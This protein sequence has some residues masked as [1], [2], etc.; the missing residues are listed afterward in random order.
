MNGRGPAPSPQPAPL[1]QNFTCSPRPLY[2]HGVDQAQ[3]IEHQL[4]ARLLRFRSQSDAED[5]KQLASDLI[6]A[7]R[8][9]DARGVVVLAQDPDAPDP[10][11]MVLE[12]SAWYLD[13][14]LARA[15]EAFIGGVELA[16][17]A[18]EP[19]LWIGRCLL[20]RGDPLRAAH[21]LERCLALDPDA[22]EAKV[23]LHRALSRIDRIE[24][25]DRRRARSTALTLPPPSEEGPHVA[26]SP[27]L[28]I[29]ALAEQCGSEAPVDDGCARHTTAAADG[30]RA[31][32]E[33][34]AEAIPV[35]MPAQASAADRVS[36]GGE[37]EPPPSTFDRPDTST[38][39]ARSGV[40]S[41]AV[42][43]PS[44]E[45]GASSAGAIEAPE[46]ASSAGTLTA[47]VQVSV[48]STDDWVERV[49]A[50]QGEY[51]ESDHE[52]LASP[53][54]PDELQTSDAADDASR[55]AAADAVASEP[56]PASSESATEPVEVDASPQSSASASVPAGTLVELTTADTRPQTQ[57]GA[58]ESEPSRS[59]VPPV[60]TTPSR[61]AEALAAPS[62]AVTQAEPRETA[63]PTETAPTEP[64]APERAPDTTQAASQAAPPATDVDAARDHDEREIDLVSG[65]AEGL[66][67]GAFARAHRR[68]LSSA[69]PARVRGAF[70]ARTLPGVTLSGEEADWSV[71]VDLASLLGMTAPGSLAA[72]T[73]TSSSGAV[74]AVDQAGVAE[75][76]LAAGL[77]ATGAQGAAFDADRDETPLRL[78]LAPRVVESPAPRRTGGVGN[79][80]MTIATMAVCA[81]AG[82]FGVAEWGRPWARLAVER[83]GSA[84]SSARAWASA[85]VATQT[86]VD[87]E[88]EDAVAAVALAQK[89]VSEVATETPQATQGESVLQPA[90]EPR[91]SGADQRAATEA[92]DVKPEAD[93]PVQAVAAEDTA[94]AISDGLER[95]R[96]AF[97]RNDL[98]AARAA[99]RPL[100]GSL[101]RSIEGRMLHAQLLVRE[102]RAERALAVAKP[103]RDLDR[104]TPLQLAVIGD[105]LHAVGEV[106][107]AAGAYELALAQ[108]PNSLPA[109]VGR[110]EIHLRAERSDDAIALLERARAQADGAS[111][112]LRARLLTALG[113]AFMQRDREG[114]RELS[115]DAL[116]QALSLPNPPVEA[117][118]WLGESQA[119]R[120]TP[121]A[122]AAYTRYLELLPKGR[123]AARA[124]RALGPLLN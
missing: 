94:H 118:F 5:P 98:E 29:E 53:E 28:G 70:S 66:P 25:E 62:G 69:P 51:S 81:A 57:S 109:L 122:T 20:D 40:A 88:T 38:E 106:N 37:S 104:R 84:V 43:T 123:Y 90:A 116:R 74:A 119:A 91:P 45:A 34:P 8:Y 24:E 18:A 14:D 42:L 75:D 111:A 95:V 49:S 32:M 50:P 1:A 102:G 59:E 89:A 55:A 110:A 79:V 85:A 78:S 15:L 87:A 58:S 6:R 12:G 121:E 16:P 117:H 68:P 13:G 61:V 113:H 10:G 26:T 120:R 86:Q 64:P 21:A 48:V 7:G 105:V 19:Y 115:A 101:K 67:I 96:E 33:A 92:I 44:L 4:N 36:A 46:M 99:F 65:F 114:D 2:M 97:D 108:A 47:P 54:L 73:H 22:A 103:V 30:L 56:E 9:G 52:G 83:V 124:K 93:T 63:E 112:Y 41:G 71:D 107:V 76:P 17:D 72:V 3:P 11:L 100:P 80:V 31:Q 60:A 39:Q 77:D 27:G 82:Y 35:L 23:L